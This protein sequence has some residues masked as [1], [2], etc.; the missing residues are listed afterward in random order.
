MPNYPDCHRLIPSYALLRRCNLSIQYCSPHHPR[1]KL[2]MASSSDTRKWS[3]YILRS[4]L[5][6]RRTRN[7]LFIIYIYLHLIC[8]SP[9]LIPSN[10]SRIHGIRFN[11]RTNILLSSHSNHKPPI[12]HPVHWP[13]SSP[14]DLRGVCSRQRHPNTIFYIPLS[15]P[16]YYRR[17]NYNPPTIPS[18]NRLK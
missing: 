3:L 11:L 5:P 18:S 13:K 9:N 16:F 2:W 14:M 7:I 10:S 8:R 15:H 17:T 1:C 12:R 4:N 6:S